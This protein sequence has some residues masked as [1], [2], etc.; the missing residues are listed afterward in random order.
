[1][2]PLLLQAV[3][4]APSPPLVVAPS[5]DVTRIERQATEAPATVQ[6]EVSAAGRTL[7]AGPLR[8][9]RGAGASYTEQ[10]SQAPAQRC[11]AEP[12]HLFRT[13]RSS[14]TVTLSPRG[15]G[16]AEMLGVEVRWTRPGDASCPNPGGTRTV[17]IEDAVKLPQ[18][19]QAVLTGD[20]GLVVKLRRVG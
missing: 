10:L 9:A 14:F 3:I 13:H 18:G 19:A 6:V 12:S 15:Y 17:Q 7:W 16:E 8:V 11:G 20:G 5:R 4:A 1:M 2:L